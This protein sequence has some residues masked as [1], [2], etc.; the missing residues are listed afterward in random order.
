MYAV[1]VRLFCHSFHSHLLFDLPLSYQVLGTV[2]GNV[3]TFLGK[4]SLPES[5]QD[6][7]NKYSDHRFVG[8]YDLGGGPSLLLRDADL[9]NTISIKD[10]DYFVNHFFQLDKKLDPLVGRTLFSMTNKSWRDMRGT[11]SPLFTG[12]KMR[13]MLTLMTDCATDFTTFIRDDIVSNSQTNGREYNMNTIM[14]YLTNDVIGSTAFGI[15][16][17][18]LR[19]PDNELYKMGTEIAYAIIG[20]KALFLIA[21]PKLATFFNLKVVTD[22]HDQFFRNVLKTTIEERK[23]RKI[24]RNDMLHLLLLAKDGQLNEVKENENDQDTGFA[25]ITEIMTTKTSEKLKSN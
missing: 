25:T 18:T 14:M 6:L 11:L 9:I 5:A 7:Y 3:D 12:S 23:K 20:M 1:A 15:E 22:R 2:L 21:F 16:M 8:M 24:V 13:Y 4:K 17:N 19:K 10:F